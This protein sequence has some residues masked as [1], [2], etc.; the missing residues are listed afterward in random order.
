MHICPKNGTAERNT[1]V[2]DRRA[3]YENRLKQN[4][5]VKVTVWASPACAERIRALA[6]ESRKALAAGVPL[7]DD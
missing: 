4:G 7:D 5:F 2:G 6:A 3:K 1:N